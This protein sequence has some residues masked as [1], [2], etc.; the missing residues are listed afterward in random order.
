[1]TGTL[2]NEPE[3]RSE[4]VETITEPLTNSS[5][6]S[7]P[8]EESSYG[9][10]VKSSSIIGG[11]QVINMAIGLVRTK[12][13]AVLI[14]P[15]GIGLM[16]IYQSITGLASTIAGLGINT[17]GVREV[18][19]F[20]GKGDAVG[21]AKTIRTLRRVSWF[22]GIAGMLLLAGLAPWISELSF[23]TRDYAWAIA[24]LGVTILLGNITAGQTAVIQGT[25]RIGDIARISVWGSA[26]GTI[27]SVGFY[28]ALGIEGMIPALIG[29]AVISLM[30]SSYYAW[31]IKLDSAA[32]TWSETWIQSRGMIQFGIAM[33][34]SG[35][36]VTG[37]A[38]VTRLL[39]A[40]ELSIE[41]VGI[42]SAAYGVSGIFVQFVLGA[43]GADFYPRL[44]TEA[45]NHPR[46]TQLINEQTEVGL[47]LAFPGLLATLVFAPWIIN[48]LYTSEFSEASELLQ[49]FVI[50][51]LGR[52]LSWPLGFSLLAKGQ[53]SLFIMTE[54]FFNLLHLG[55]I[56][57]GL[58][59]MGLPGTAAAFALLYVA[60]A[61]TM[62]IIN[63]LTIDFRWTHQ[64]WTQLAWMVPIG[65][66]I[67][68]S[69]LMLPTTA[70]MIVGGLLIIA[71]GLICL[72]QLVKRL[73]SNHKLSLLFAWL[74][75]RIKNFPSSL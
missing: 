15:S 38:Y 46:M 13:V 3:E 19:Q 64:V 31:Q 68:A 4:L 65:A 61:G 43:M 7:K 5:P 50:G 24:A 26:A 63:K 75:N 21:V 39:I 62:L 29:L 11:A 33:V 53:S 72:N 9:Q 20:H 23:G 73:G 25:R 2:T 67:F 12:L 70:A 47:L 30:V 57:V 36:M 37:V 69:S 45:N 32:P 49:W 58:Q 10:I 48:L 35:I 16:A 51:C 6:V 8:P 34:I 1:V 22:S 66:A 56:W 28:W 41:S 59:T 14:G 60:Y 52:V 74:N 42:Y 27:V 44:T 17:S 55:L 18:A 71:S 40:N 54:T